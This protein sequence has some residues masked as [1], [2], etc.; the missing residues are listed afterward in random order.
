MTLQTGVVLLI[1]L[2]YGWKLGLSTVL[3]YLGKRRLWSKFH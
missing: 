1:G 2:A 3:L